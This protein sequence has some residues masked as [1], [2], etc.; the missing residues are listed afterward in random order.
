MG[1]VWTLRARGLAPSLGAGGS[2]VVAALCC[3][4]LRLGDARLP[5]LARPRRGLARTGRSRCPCPPRKAAGRAAVRSRPPPRRRR[6]RRAAPRPRAAARAARRRAAPA[7]APPRAPGPGGHE[8]AA[9]PRPR[10][11][12]PAPAAARAAPRPRPP[13]PAPQAP[14]QPE[15]ARAARPGRDASSRPS[16]ADETAPPL[17][18]VVQ[19][20]RSQP[21]LDTVQQVGRTVDETAGA[22]APDPAL[23]DRP[24]RPRRRRRR[25]PRP[26]RGRASVHALLAH[27]RARGVDVG[28]RAARRRR[29]GARRRLVGRRRGAGVPD[30]GRGSGRP[31]CSS[32]PRGCCASSTTRRRASTARAASGRC[33]RASRPR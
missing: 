8:P 13:R 28:A 22:A 19:R 29:R 30:A 27:L 31:R 14:A 25:A 10:R 33:R 24:R 32:A 2:L 15:P 3:L 4:L 12:A 6:R 9:P 11:P 5:R 20:S 23:V 26:R 21:V 16:A 1:I 17:P 18:P 7:A